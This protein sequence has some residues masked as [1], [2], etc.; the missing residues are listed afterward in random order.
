MEIT[1]SVVSRGKVDG[2]DGEAGVARDSPNVVQDNSPVGG[3]DILVLNLKSNKN[4][5]RSKL[6]C[7][8][9]S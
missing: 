8:K 6:V 2:T 9:K 4:D 1:S 7:A 5:V 3:K